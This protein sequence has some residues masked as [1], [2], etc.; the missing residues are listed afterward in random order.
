M[1]KPRH[2]EG[3][4]YSENWVDGEAR[5]FGRAAKTRRSTAVGRAVFHH[6]QALRLHAMK[7]WPSWGIP[8]LLWQT[9]QPM[10]SLA[11][12]WVP[13]DDGSFFR[14]SD[15]QRF[16]SRIDHDA[17]AI[18]DCQENSFLSATHG[19]RSNLDLH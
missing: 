8:G 12:V 14:S 9:Q 10:K 5:G 18:P 15:P 16:R 1:R 4:E 19:F 3:A 6:S 2:Y 13:G 7:P 17:F 11:M